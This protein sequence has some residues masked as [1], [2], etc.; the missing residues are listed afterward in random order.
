M[1]LRE[2]FAPVALAGLGL[3]RRFVPPPHGAFRILLF[4][5]V[6][7]ALST[8]FSALIADI[9]QRDGFLTPAQAVARLKGDAPPA[10][11]RVPCLISFDDGFASNRRIAEDVL[12]AHQVKGLFFVC[13]GLIDLAPAERPAAVARG[14][15]DGRV[16]PESPQASAPL[17]EWDDIRALS[18]AGHEIG[19]HSM[20]HRRLAGLDPQQLAG[21]VGGSCDRLTDRLG[22]PPTWFAWP[23]GDIGSV[24]ADALSAIGRHVPFCRSG[25]RGINRPGQNRLTIF[26]DH[27]DLAASPAWRAL[28]MAG[29]LDGRYRTARARLSELAA[30]NHAQTGP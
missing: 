17:M 27:I 18:E 14:I 26:A 10:D 23:F 11:G 24:D 25:V 8:A 29:G 30:A 5:D 9:A 16:A 20:T 12:A 7:A 2:T 28:T 22:R 1:T 6:P 13:P 4:H 15:F 19:A 21:E 3:L